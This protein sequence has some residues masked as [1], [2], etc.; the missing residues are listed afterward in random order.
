M[1]KE[2]DAILN[3]QKATLSHQVSQTLPDRFPFF[4][5]V[6]YDKSVPFI[7]TSLLKAHRCFACFKLDHTSPFT[8]DLYPLSTV[9]LYKTYQALLGES[10]GR[11]PRAIPEFPAGLTSNHACGTQD[12]RGYG[13]SCDSA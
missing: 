12:R 7:P 5:Y 11:S 10:A 3:S 4:W 8:R 6:E 1:R 13:E 2:P 9:F